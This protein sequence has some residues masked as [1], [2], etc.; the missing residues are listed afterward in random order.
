MNSLMRYFLPAMIAM[1]LPACAAVKVFPEHRATTVSPE[2]VQTRE[3]G[4]TL[5]VQRGDTLYRIA[6]RL[7]VSVRDLA[8]WNAI[9]VPL[10]DSPRAAAA[11]PP[12]RSANRG[13]EG[14]RPGRQAAAPHSGRRRSARALAGGEAIAQ[15]GGQQR[16]IPGRARS[17]ALA[18]RWTSHPAAASRRADYP[19]SP[20]RGRAGRAGACRR[21]RH[22]PVLG[23][24]FAGIRGSG[25][26]QSPGQLG[27]VLLPQPQTIGGRGPTHQG[28]R[29]DR[30]DGQDRS[31]ERNGSLRAAPQRD[32]GRPIAVSAEAIEELKTSASALHAHSTLR[33]SIV[34][35]AARHPPGSRYHGGQSGRQRI[36]AGTVIAG[37]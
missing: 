20:Y 2:A 11:H 17:L 19:G 5:V 9:G 7:G 37:G 3:G 12:R 35:E 31:R 14:R 8:S 22:R 13:S 4:N 18:G 30:R 36:S 10:H 1:A 21:R 28:R 24:R 6:S 27:V 33:Q 34:V 15:Q 16:C 32:A 25:R 29:A 23:K 26:H